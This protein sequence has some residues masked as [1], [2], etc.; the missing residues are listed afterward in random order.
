MK[1]WASESSLEWIHHASRCVCALQQALGR[2]FAA[3][4][5]LS[6]FKGPWLAASDEHR[7]NI[8]LE[9]ICRAMADDDL[10]LARMWCP[11]STLDHLTSEHGET[12][13]RLLHL[14]LPHSLDVTLS[15]PNRIPHLVV[16]RSL[17]ISPVLATKPGCRAMAARVEI[18]RIHCLTRIVREI[19]FAFVRHFGAFSITVC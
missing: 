11:D 15:A 1:E 10:H 19:F 5:M 7:R 2:D 14:L 13:L 12:Y 18:A 17:S 6:E 3:I 4:S 16:D 9:G 8:T